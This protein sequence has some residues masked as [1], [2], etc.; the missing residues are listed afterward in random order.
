[1]RRSAKSDD[2]FAEAASMAS[3]LS[4]FA[5][6]NLPV[7]APLASYASHTT[8]FA[9]RSGGSPPLARCFTVRS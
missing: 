6:S 9:A 3:T 4:H 1:M 8:S 5:L 2:L 7:S